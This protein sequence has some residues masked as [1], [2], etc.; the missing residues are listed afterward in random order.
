RAA[1]AAIGRS[2]TTT[3]A[4]GLQAD[5]SGTSVRRAKRSVSFA[6]RRRVHPGGVRL[7]MSNRE[8]WRAASML[9]P[10][11]G[12]ELRFEVGLQP[13]LPALVADAALLPA[14]EGILGRVGRP[15]VH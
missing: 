12:D 2:S 10:A 1:L 3:P 4:R 8:A 5:L 7:M 6:A 9:K 11:D 14:P 13:F 15:V